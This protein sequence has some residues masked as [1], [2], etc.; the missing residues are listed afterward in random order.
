[1]DA[2]E[3]DK[4]IVGLAMQQ[5]HRDGEVEIPN[6]GQTTETIVVDTDGNQHT[7]SLISE[8]DDNGAYVMA[9][10]WVDFSLTPLDKEEVADDR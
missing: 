1:M 2:T 6:W 8:G 10:V 5:W 4:Y 3:R 7:I 9:W